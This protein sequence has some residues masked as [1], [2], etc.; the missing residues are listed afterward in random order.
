MQTCPLYG[1][2]ATVSLRALV[3]VLFASNMRIRHFGTTKGF[4]GMVSEPV[5]NWFF[6]STLQSL[7]L[8]TCMDVGPESAP[9]LKYFGGLRRL[10]IGTHDNLCLLNVLTSYEALEHLTIERLTLATR[11]I[12]ITDP[13][14]HRYLKSLTFNSSVLPGCILGIAAASCPELTYFAIEDCVVAHRGKAVTHIN[15]SR[16]ELEHIL[17]RNVTKL[18]NLGTEEAIP[19]STKQDGLP[20]MIFG[21]EQEKNSTEQ[22]WFDLSLPSTDTDQIS[23]LLGL[24]P[25]PM[26]SSYILQR[27]QTEALLAIAITC[28]AVEQI[29]INRKRLLY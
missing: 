10:H 29:H 17:L 18:N 28:Q 24:R 25:S 4:S 12:D 8:A 14:E 20:L 5:D 23:T 21:L 7:Y 15:L 3:R 6:H 2:I 22:H 11:E 9:F 19:R 13:V 1:T 26:D 16:S 27:L